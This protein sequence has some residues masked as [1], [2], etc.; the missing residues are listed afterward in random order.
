MSSAL[1][2]R[3]RSIVYNRTIVYERQNFLKIVVHVII[4]DQCNQNRALD[5]IQVARIYRCAI[6]SHFDI[7]VLLKKAGLRHLGHW[8][9]MQAQI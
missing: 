3:F 5:E 2:N 7:R 6:L 4:I 1:T 8:Q 9:T